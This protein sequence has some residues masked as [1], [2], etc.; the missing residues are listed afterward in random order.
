MK[1]ALFIMVC[2]IAVI[3]AVLGVMAIA[4]F[5]RMWRDW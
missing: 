5:I 3:V 2:V 4:M 1:T